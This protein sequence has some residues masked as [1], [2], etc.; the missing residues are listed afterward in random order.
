[1]ARLSYILAFS[2][3]ALAAGGQ[4]PETPAVEKL[5]WMAGNWR[6]EQGGT[7]IEEW[8][9]SPRGGLMLGLHRDVFPTGEAFFE[10]LR[11]EE[12]Q[13][14]L[15]Y[16]ASPKGRPAVPFRLEKLEPQR[17]VFS[18][19]DH[20]YPQRII[21]WLEDAELH[22]RIEG[23]TPEGAKSSEWVYRKSSE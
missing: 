20:D 11:I 21:Y 14:G 5:A 15:V 18:K 17:A 22:A 3:L 8:W 12:T 13:D 19:P 4:P 9:T 16:M 23:D 2:I 6:G 7:S 10:Y 1:M